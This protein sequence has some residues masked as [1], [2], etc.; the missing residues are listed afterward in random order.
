V[1]TQLYEGMF[2]V[3]NETVRESWKAAKAA[4]TDVLAKHG[5]KIET[6]R[7]WDERRLVYPIQRRLRAT[8]LLVHFELDTQAIAGLRRDLELS[9]RVLR[10]LL[11]S[12]EAVPE[13]EREL[14]QVELA[15]DFVVPEPPPEVEAVVE[16]PE[17]EEAG[18]GAGAEAK[19][20]KEESKDGEGAAEGAKS[21]KKPAP[22]SE[23]TEKP[24][25]AEAAA[26]AETKSEG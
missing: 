16:E 9:E 20:E 5:A 26:T 22:A 24:A 1:R 15:D 13:G 10:Y 21:E 6:A 25:T 4:V 19:G 14:S 12:V 11:K 2:L 8:Y 17:K 23:S 3:D 18:E 7:R